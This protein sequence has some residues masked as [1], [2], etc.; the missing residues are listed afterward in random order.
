MGDEDWT[1]IDRKKDKQQRKKDSVVSNGH[2][3]AGH[4]ARGRGGGQRGGGGRGRGGERGGTLPRKNSNKPPRGGS[5]ASGRGGGRGGS[6][7][8]SGSRGVTPQPQPAAV[9]AAPAVV[10]P[11]SWAAKLS[12][13][14]AVSSQEPPQQP[15]PAAPKPFSWAS[16]SASNSQSSSSRT[17]VTSVSDNQPE[18]VP[19]TEVSST[20]N[21]T[22][23][24]DK[25][26]TNPTNNDKKKDIP[27]ANKD[28]SD[29]LDIVEDTIKDTKDE[30]SI[31]K[32]SENANTNAVI[33]EA[34]EAA[35]DS[36]GN[37]TTD[38]NKNIT[39]IKCLAHDESHDK[40]AAA[41]EPLTNGD[42]ATED[43]T[44]EAEE[45]EE[46]EVKTEA[47]IPGIRDDRWT[48]LN[49]DGKKQYD[50]DFLI[51]LQTNPLSLQKPGT[52]PSNM[53]V[54]LNSPN[55]D[56]IGRVTSAPNLKMFDQ[57]AIRSSVS[58]N[59]GTPRRGDSR[60]KES[61][62]GAGK[63]INLQREEVKLNEAEN[64]WKPS[65]KESSGELLDE[66]E[67]LCKKV[68]SILNKLCP[69]KFDSLVAQFNS[70]VIDNEEKLT[71]AMEL[72]FEKALDEPVFS[73]AYARMC[74]HLGN[75]NVMLKDEKTPL[76]F[77]TLLLQR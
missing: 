48:P 3:G 17:S 56:T 27:L 5:S 26:E 57:P 38:D 58:Y 9:T 35:P 37:F 30:E 7:S 59:R 25:K 32:L 72:V 21:A 24:N 42:I 40:V 61:R 64:A 44:A 46:E 1:T 6:Q 53:E 12:G 55:L 22:T 10:N 20:E 69:Q 47:E 76:N 4:E 52:L 19:T 54:I 2:V 18:P 75:K 68:R 73:V 14:A 29:T 66:V 16:V 63:V 41:Q 31:D 74:Q 8:Q 34:A 11:N 23:D 60:R 15:A 70:L 36:N 71:K 39:N 49:T 65:K 43:E 62:Q 77:R 45:A 33:K 67:S 50:R 51:S 13:A 28:A